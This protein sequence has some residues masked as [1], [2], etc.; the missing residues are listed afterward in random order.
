MIRK[1][2]SLAR[3]THLPSKVKIFRI[4]KTFISSSSSITKE[5]IFTNEH[6]ELRR[7]LNKIIEKDINPF[8]DEW[9]A[10]FKFPAHDV[11]KKLGNAGFLGLNKP[12]KYGGMGLDFTYNVA[13]AEELGILTI[14]CRS[15]SRKSILNSIVFILTNPDCATVQNKLSSKYIN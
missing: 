12:K 13:M 6:V 8:V 7:S 10:A 15:A 3:L 1:F 4:D 9:E 14:N 2:C 11:F 5:A